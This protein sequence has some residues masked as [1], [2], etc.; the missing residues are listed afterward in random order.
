MLDHGRAGSVR[1][2]TRTRRCTPRAQSTCVLFMGSP[3]DAG[4]RRTKEAPHESRTPLAHAA[5]T[6]I[7]V[8]RRDGRAPVGRL[9]GRRCGCRPGFPV[10]LTVGEQNVA[11]TL[12]I[13]NV[14]PVGQPRYGD[15]RGH[16][17]HAV[18]WRDVRREPRH[19]RQLGPR[20]SDGSEDVG[21][22]AL[23]ARGPARRH[24]L[25]G[26]HLRP[27]RRPGPAPVSTR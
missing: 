20:L 8:V 1:R 17:A 13:Q 15:S 11:A 9:R 6:A 16:H 25:R 26:P 27:R 21:V 23:S 19:G 7:A 22:F 5:L 10:S 2:S 3:V 14:Q 4:Y 12:T 24:R 18:L